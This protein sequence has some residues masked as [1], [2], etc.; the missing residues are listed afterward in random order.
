MA[1]DEGE[2]LTPDEVNSR[3]G[4]HWCR[5]FLT[6]VD[7]EAGMVRIVEECTVKGT[8]DW[9]SWNRRRASGI[10]KD[11]S[12]EGTTLTMDGR[13]RTP[14]ARVWRV[15]GLSAAIGGT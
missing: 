9:D 14:G 12:V 11:V 1:D 2:W 7:E 3:Y 13:T 4:D 6:L 5:G 8:V 15:A 10:V